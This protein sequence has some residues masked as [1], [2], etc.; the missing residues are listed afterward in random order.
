MPDTSTS[1]G[2]KLRSEINVTPLVDVVLV[3]LIIF[4]VVSPL[5]QRGFDLEVP[6]E[7]EGPPPRVLEVPDV[8]RLADQRVARLGEVDPDLVR[9]AGLEPNFAERRAA[10]RLADADVGDRALALTGV[11]RRSAQP[12]AA[13]AG[14]ALDRASVADESRP[15]RRQRPARP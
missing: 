13:I 5:L 4:M 1:G 11:A 14:Q 10:Q 7:I 2:A 12:V 8:H 9:L 6:R 3:L 15:V